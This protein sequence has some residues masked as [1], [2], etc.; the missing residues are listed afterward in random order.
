M[1]V[2]LKFMSILAVQA[3]LGANETLTFELPSGATLADLLAVMDSQIGERFPPQTWNRDTCQFN[4]QVLF[5]VNNTQISDLSTP[6]QDGDI[7]RVYVP[8]SGG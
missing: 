7:V 2:S 5:L 6:L 8:I 3:K 1:H 4:K